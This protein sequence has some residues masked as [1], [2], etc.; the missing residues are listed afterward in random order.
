MVTHRIATLVLLVAVSVGGVANSAL[1]THFGCV[2]SI[3]PREVA[4]G[5]TGVDFDLTVTNG[6]MVL[7]EV[8]SSFVDPVNH[9]SAV[10]APGF[11]LVSASAPAPWQV[12]LHSRWPIVRYREGNM[13]AF[14]SV[15]FGF[16]ADVPTVSSE[17]SWEFQIQASLDDGDTYTDCDPEFEGATTVTVR[18]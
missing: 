16:E 13:S 9:V 18:P 3:A 14:Q 12:F 17:R 5:A 11:S 6:F 1:G 4:S 8:P 7:G 10:M 2:A 15:T